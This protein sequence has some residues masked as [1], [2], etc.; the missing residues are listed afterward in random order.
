MSQSRNNITREVSRKSLFPDASPLI[1]TTLSYN[2]GDLLYF[3]SSTK[4]IKLAAAES[5]ASTLLGVAV[6]KIVE[7]IPAQPYNTA[8]SA[9]QAQGALPGP[10]YGVIVSL[11][12]KN[13]DAL[14]RGSLVYADPVTGAQNVQAA[15]T[16]A[17]GL[18]QGAN[19]TGGTDTLI[20]VLLGARYPSDSL[21]F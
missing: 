13:G 15:G 6:Q 8:T 1:P 17:I 5:E 11:Y 4:R 7:G 10:A 18:Y 16:K 3:D 20:E 2:Q 14:A 12:L 19:I 9:S 21:V